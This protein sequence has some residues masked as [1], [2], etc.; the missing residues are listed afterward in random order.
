MMVADVLLHNDIPKEIAEYDKK[1]K[2]ISQE[3]ERLKKQQEAFEKIS[4]IVGNFESMIEG[5][6]KQLPAS[7]TIIMPIKIIVKRTINTFSIL[8]YTMNIG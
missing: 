4:N 3:R 1:A 2:E 8:D 5:L 6:E 7:K